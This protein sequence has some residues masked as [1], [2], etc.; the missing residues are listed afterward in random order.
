MLGGSP[1][2]SALS[3][4]HANMISQCG[5]YPSNSTQTPQSDCAFPCAGDPS[6]L[7]GATARLSLYLSNDT[8]K[9]A[10]DPAVPGPVIGNY[11]YAACYVDSGA[12][13]LLANGP[14]A[15][16]EGNVTTEDCIARAE[17]GGWKFAGLEFGSEC[18]VGNALGAGGGNGRTREGECGMSCTG[19]RREVCGGA[20]RMTVWVRN[21]AV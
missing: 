6:S 21:A 4:S 1:S 20:S 13:R 11:T 8:S 2:L 14:F 5:P 3:H 17:T 9:I 12:P 7:C 18:W 19:A 16:A 10:T 15:G